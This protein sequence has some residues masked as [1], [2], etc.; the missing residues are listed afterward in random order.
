L[1]KY[2]IW[3]FLN[4]EG[5]ALWGDVFPDGEVHIQS[6][7]PQSATLEGI[8]EQ[9]RVFLLN[10]QALSAQHQEAVL[11]KISRKLWRKKGR[12]SGTK[13]DVFQNR[14]ARANAAIFKVLAKES[15]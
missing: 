11:E 10:W 7:I 1:R 13:L 9:E 5:K 3:T 6:L 2:V 14:V 4:A 8:N 15:P 12:S